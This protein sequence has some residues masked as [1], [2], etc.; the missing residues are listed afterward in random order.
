MTDQEQLKLTKPPRSKKTGILYVC[1]RCLEVFPTPSTAKRHVE[2]KRKCHWFQAGNP[3]LQQN[4]EA[5]CKLRYRKALQDYNE[6]A[7]LYFNSA[8][9]RNDQTE[10]SDILNVSTFPHFELL[11]TIIEQTKTKQPKKFFDILAMLS[12]FSNRDDISIARKMRLKAF[13][14]HHLTL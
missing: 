14:D 12:D 7:S 9:E 6:D 13:V 8:L 10:L 2:R 5:L 11:L 4:A 3:G 1:E